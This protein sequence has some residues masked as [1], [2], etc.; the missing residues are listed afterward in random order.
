[1]V[2]ELTARPGETAAE[3]EARV[4][5]VV[6]GRVPDVRLALARLLDGD[7]A[8]AAG[9]VGLDAARV[10]LVGHSFGGWTV[11][12]TPDTE[13]RVRAVVA[14]APAG[15]SRPRPGI[16]PVT[17]DFAWTHT[18][19]TLVLAGD[20]DVMTPLDGIVEV[21]RRMPAPKR[22]F[23]LRGADHLHFGDDAEE[24]HES[25]RRFALPGDAAWIPS[26]MRPVAKLCPPDDAHAFARGLALAHLDASL[27]DSRVAGAW[28]A[29]HATQALSAR[30]IDAWEQ[31]GPAPPVSGP[32]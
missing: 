23:V 32:G 3:R 9:G 6:A 14:M 18:V 28:L 29:D 11:L 8:T 1:V 7:P 17:L 2:P 4:A 24:A 26:A 30:G 15:S 27:R 22:M 19:A 31:R 25:L 16:L 5:T 13:P 10:G 12:A 21:F 20:E